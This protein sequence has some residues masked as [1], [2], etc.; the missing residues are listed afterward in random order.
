MGSAGDCIDSVQ[1]HTDLHSC[2]SASQGD[3][4]GDWYFPNGTQLPL[5]DGVLNNIFETRVVQR[6][7]LRLNM[8][9]HPEYFTDHSGVP[10]RES[11]R[12]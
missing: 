12:L 10:N 3:D 11:S 2:C 6:V 4:R 8:T 5:L 1:C 9:S 7:D